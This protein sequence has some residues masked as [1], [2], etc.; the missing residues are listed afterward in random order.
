M[1]QTAE[2]K[3]LF[4]NNVL[5]FKGKTDLFACLVRAGGYEICSA[6]TDVS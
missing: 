1:T 3:G 4:R 6:F 5:Q 2:Q